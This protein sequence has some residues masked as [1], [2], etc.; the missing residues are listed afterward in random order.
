VWVWV[1]V[2]VW[3]GCVCVC[4]G[5]S[6]RTFMCV[7]VCVREGKA[8]AGAAMGADWVPRCVCECGSAGVIVGSGEGFQARMLETSV[9]ANAGAMRHSAALAAAWAT[10]PPP[11]GSR[12]PAAVVQMAALALH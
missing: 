9:M 2:W 1:W 10:C 7:Y 11:C 6:A 12:Q 4:G 3:V 8:G 5:V